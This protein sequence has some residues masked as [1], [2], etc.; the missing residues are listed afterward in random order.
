MTFKKAYLFYFALA[1]IATVLCVRIVHE[2][3]LWWQLRT[4]EYIIEKG[5]VPDV[6]V[7]SFTYDGKPWL[8][9]K[10][11]FEVIQATIANALGPEFLPVPQF[12]A[13][14]AMLLFLLLIIRNFSTTTKGTPA[15]ISM[16]LLLFL[17]G[18]SYRMNGRP[19]LVSYTFTAFY[20]FVF[21]QIWRGKRG[22]IFALLP[23]QLLW[24]NMHEGYGTG[25]VM[26]AIFMA[27]M[28]FEFWTS[29]K[30]GSQAR[31]ALLRQSAIFAAS[32]LVVAIHPGGLQMIWHPYEIF[33]QLSENQFTQEIYSA[34]NKA[35][36]HMPAFVGLGLGAIAAWH[37]WQSGKE[38]GRFK[39]KQLSSAYP[40]FYLVL[41]AAFFY[42]SLKSYRNLPFLLLISTPLVAAQLHQMFGAV[43]VKK[44]SWAVALVFL[45]FYVSIGTNT[46]Y[47]AFLP[48]EEFG[49]G[50]SNAKNP[51]G[52]AQ[53]IQSKNLS[54]PAFS[55][56]LSSSYL[57][58]HLQPDF[59]TFVDLRD[60]DVFEADDMEISL[61]CCN[62][63]DKRL[64]DGQSIWEVIDG[65][66]NFNYVV[67]LNQ[68]EFLPLH[69]YLAKEGLFKLA[70]ADALCSV[71]VCNNE[72][73]S[74]L[75]ASLPADVFQPTQPNYSDSFA[76]LF[77]PF[78]KPKNQTPQEFEAIRAA[79]YATIGQPLP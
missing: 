65:R 57:L 56:Y 12:F 32:W 2:P 16:A 22:W 74:T 41:F 38:K 18:M 11:G 54:G 59:K 15:L 20:L 28:W 52:A 42:L 27:S 13:N 35:Y 26:S 40:F 69:R 46:F 21:T 1:A 33:T 64:A 19:E 58:W 67:V 60:L 73:N 8:N 75:L 39:F 9:V 36:W 49:W 66:Y 77:W 48:A 79:Y 44:V 78:Y 61:I 72:A 37:L 63:P 51:I 17:V 29:S 47:K 23:A 30:K 14:G 24:A 10:W 34:A 6:D 62:Q 4:G 50:I 68:A 45:G 5:T 25:M 31:Q 76:Q 53:F 55:D 3:D 71:F 43:S 70:Y 7:F